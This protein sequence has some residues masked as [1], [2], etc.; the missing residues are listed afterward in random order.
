MK[1]FTGGEGNRHRYSLVSIN[2]YARTFPVFILAAL[3]VSAAPVNAQTAAGR[4]DVAQPNAARFPEVT[5]YAYPTDGRGALIS[6]LGKEAFQVTEDGASAPVLRVEAKGG[7]LDV[8]L[9]LDRSPSMLNWNKLEYA[10]RAAREFI[11]QLG[12]EDRAALITFSSGCTLDQG[13][14]RDQGALLAAI[15]RAQISGDSTTFLDAVYWSIT[16]VA[17]QQTGSV[18][19]V[20]PARADARRVV[21][22]LTDGDD[23]SSRAL[24]QELIDYARNNGVSLYMVALGADPLVG[25]M[26]YL[27]KETGGIFQ[28]APNPQ[29][30]Q[31]LYVAMAQQLRREYRVTFRTPRPALDNSRR[32]VRLTVNGPNLQTTTW[33]R[34]PSQGSV[35]MT[36]PEPPQEG[37]AVSGAGHRKPVEP[38]LLFGAVLMTVGLAGG[39]IA[40]FVWL[41]KRR[42]LPIQD[43]NPRLDLLPLWVR[44]GCT[45]IG[46]SKECELVLDGHQISRVHARIELVNGVCRLFDEGSSNGTYVNG[47]RVHRSRKLRIGDVIRIGDREFRFAGQFRG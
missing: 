6:G 29:D 34:A 11:Q 31:A 17:L 23:R 13:L 25:Q 37:A 14:T 10:K 3:L 40:L 43:S 45:R 19:G 4:L 1:Q 35:L 30:L 22:A 18:T 20:T 16:Q 5:L 2:V 26:Q 38:S 46:R 32:E 47:Q 21:L 28:R 7:S 27:A 15:E 8:C 36:V 33:Y 12:A 9:A 42:S 39:I 44:E 41:G 24:P